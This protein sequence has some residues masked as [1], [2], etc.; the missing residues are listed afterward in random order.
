[1]APPIKKA[2]TLKDFDEE[3]EGRGWG[4]VPTNEIVKI[5]KSTKSTCTIFFLKNEKIICAKSD[6]IIRFENMR[7][8]FDFINNEYWGFLKGRSKR[9]TGNRTIK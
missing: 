2:F 3:E 5:I 1:M 9:K 8:V 6:A 4:L 7:G